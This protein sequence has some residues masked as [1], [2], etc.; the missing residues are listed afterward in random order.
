MHKSKGKLSRGGME[1]MTVGSESLLE[2]VNLRTRES[3]LYAQKKIKMASC[4]VPGARNR[5]TEVE[6]AM[7]EYYIRVLSL[8]Q[9]WLNKGEELIIP[10]YIWMVVAGEKASGKGGGR[11]LV[12]G[13]WEHCRKST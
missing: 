4:N 12:R 6:N 10:G 13:C 9:T 8:S 5:V 2:A 11:F 7:K 3:G 1:E